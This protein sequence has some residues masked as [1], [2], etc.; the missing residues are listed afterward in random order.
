MKKENEAK[1]EESESNY[2]RNVNEL[3]QEMED[4]LVTKKER[5]DKD[6]LEHV[7]ASTCNEAEN[8]LEIQVRGIIK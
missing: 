8:T 5:E 7:T 3:V 4:R 2:R 1:N 6:A